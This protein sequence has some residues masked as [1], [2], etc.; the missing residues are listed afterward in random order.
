MKYY[1]EIYWPKEPQK[2]GRPLGLWF[3]KGKEGKADKMEIGDKV[4]LYETGTHPDD[5][6]KGNKKIFGSV[7][8]SGGKK[9]YSE[10]EYPKVNGMSWNI[11]IP[12]EKNII[13]D[14]GNG[15]EWDIIRKMLGWEKG[16]AIRNGPLQIKKEDF[17]ELENLLKSKNGL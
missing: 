7:T 17:K 11:Y 5:G 13:V 3:H 4:L 8:V 16:S 15:I 12:I 2:S 6:V 9:V 10:N 14:R 1:I